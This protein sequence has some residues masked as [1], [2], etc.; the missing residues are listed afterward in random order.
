MLVVFGFLI[1]VYL[2]IQASWAWDTMKLEIA[3]SV[4]N[5][6]TKISERAKTK[7][8]D[9]GLFFNEFQYRLEK[10]PKKIEITESTKKFVF[11]SCMVFLVVGIYVKTSKKKTIT[12]KEHGTSEWESLKRTSH[13]TAES[14]YKSELK[15][16]KGNATEKAAQK[17]KL[18]EKY[19]HEVTKKILLKKEHFMSNRLLSAPNK[20][21]MYNYELNNNTLLLG[22]SGSGKTRGYILPNILQA[23]SSGIVLDPKGEILGKT[24][25]FLTKVKG[26]KVRVLNLDNNEESDGFNPFYYI[27]RDRAGWEE[28]VLQLIE[29]LIM[30][31]DG[32]EQQK[33]PDPFWDKAERL[34]LQAIFFAVL[35]EFKEEDCNLNT[36]NTMIKWLQISE[37]QDPRCSDLDV[38]F[39]MFAEK[40]GK[41]H[42]AVEQWQE[43]RSKATGKTAK[44]IVVAAVA[45]LSAT[46]IASIRRILAKDELQL[47]RVGEEKTMIF[48]V[49][50][51]QKHNCDF[52]AGMFF[53]ILFDE[54][55][56]CATVKYKVEQQLPVPVHFYLDEFANTCKIPDFVQILS[57]ARSLGI[58]IT[59]VLQSLAQ[60]KEMFE[61]QWETILDTT[62]S[63]IYLGGIRSENT[64]K[65]ISTLIGTGTFDEKEY[66]RTKGRHG[67]SSVSYKKIKRELLDY[68]EVQRMKK[69]KC[70]VFLSGYNAYYVDKYNYKHHPNYKF[71]SDYRKKFYYDYTPIYKRVESGVQSE[72]KE[73]ELL[74]VKYEMEETRTIDKIVSENA[75]KINTDVDEIARKLKA[76]LIELDFVSGALE[77]E[78]DEE[79]TVQTT[80][81]ETNSEVQKILND[82]NNEVGEK[83]YDIIFDNWVKPN[84]EPKEV[85]E[86]VLNLAK[87][88]ENL[89]EIQPSE[90]ETETEETE[91]SLHGAN[92]SSLFAD[93]SSKEVT[94]D[95]FEFDN[96]EVEDE[97]IAKVV[98]LG[99]NL[100]NAIQDFQNLDFA[101][102]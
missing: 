49:K 87:D 93:N 12:G 57:Y 65:Y 32:G 38:F 13:L 51:P 22:G 2:S 89:I 72:Q 21:C 24:G 9:L 86:T 45:R 8:V 3:E 61:K 83:L 47:D 34:F 73:E 68:S 63:F 40:H 35:T 74:D 80:A 11:Y 48:V 59:V 36:A 91:T 44:S 4:K 98:N 69:K 84:L 7:G 94:E 90:D 5:N 42:I 96:E 15:K 43:F 100:T 20:L 29:V 54:L 77:S 18:S 52:I 28:R 70:L 50:A 27:H 23:N 31:T 26:Y 97:I 79:L 56:Y 33:S 95:G 53:S 25:Y 76:N 64:L 75:I 85:E 6:D 78:E 58:G 101:E 60:I 102:D 66:S 19:G 39:E 82:D 30:N 71:T 81:D 88:K 10:E 46:K 62:N 37:E 55:N 1:V 41:E 17:Q 16:I 67:S 99:Y 92:F 14:L